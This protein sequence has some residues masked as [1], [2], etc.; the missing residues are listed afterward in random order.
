MDDGLDLRSAAREIFTEALQSVDAGRAVRE[1]VRLA[2]SR[3]TV[4]D[5]EFDT[6]ACSAI[7][8]IPVGKAAG[9]MAVA[10]DSVLGDELAGGVVSTV[11]TELHISNCWRVFAGGHPTPNEASLAAAQA[12]FDLLRQADA[13][14]LV[15]F[16]ISG[17]GSAMLEWPRSAQTTL[18]EL[19]EA[20]RVLTSCGATIAEINA[21]RRHFSA[22]KGGK[23]SDH[24]PHAHQVT[25]IISDTNQGD[26]A[27]VASGLT[28]VP[29]AAAVDAASV[30]ERYKLAARLPQS[31]F[32]TINQPDTRASEH[33]VRSRRRHYVLLDNERAM[34]QA[35][36]AAHARGFTVEIER[37]IVE[38]P[39][40]EGCRML[41]SR[42][43][44]LYVRAGRGQ[45]VCSISG[46]EFAC[47][48]RGP[49]LGGR[50]VET[51]LRCAF[52][53]T[54][55]AHRSDFETL[56][57]VALSAG[58]DGVDGN[59]PAAGALSDS[60][61]LHRAH[62]LNLDAQNFLD[63]SDAYTF[64]AN[65]GDAVM[66]GPSGTNVRDLRIMLAR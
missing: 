36:A 4:V 47:P 51:A 42:L 63:A 24:A 33:N 9:S 35:A 2:G 7:Y 41:V 58:T 29:P 45:V 27:N 28:L 57:I 43:L 10:L 19:R 15:I 22:V 46:G 40:V 65:L 20:N 37:D 31:I 66:T 26:E 48:V 49:G 55:Q 30:I 13:S 11:P 60:T 23:L 6:G 21:V 12:S 64:F 39:I 53:M 25:L 54:G 18:A 1:A 32:Q 34:K 8:A 44:D 3:L 14:A 16:L 17:G 50:N 59:S 56:Q 62:T 5:Q 61:T 52:E 38:Q